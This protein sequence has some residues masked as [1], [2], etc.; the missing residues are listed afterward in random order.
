[1]LIYN[2]DRT[3]MYQA[4]LTDEVRKLMGGQLKVYAIA[5]LDGKKRIHIRRLIKSQKW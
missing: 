1:M 4:D 5:T 2:Q 3:V